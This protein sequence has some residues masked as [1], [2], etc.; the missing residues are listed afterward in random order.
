MKKIRTL[1]ILGLAIIL[2]LLMAAI[3]AVPALAYTYDA[4]IDP[5]EG[6]IGT[7]ITVVGESWGWSDTY[8]RWVTIFF[9]DEEADV[10][11][12]IDDEVE[13]Y[14]KVVSM[15]TVEEDDDGSFEATFDVPDTLSDGADDVDVESGDYFLYFTVTNETA[16]EVSTLIRE[17]V[18]F[19]VTSSGDVEID[20]EEGPVDTF[21]EITGEDFISKKDIEIDFDGHEIDIEDGDDKTDSNGDFQSF[22][23]IPEST[24]GDHTI[25]VIVSSSE[26]EVDFTVEPDIIITPQSGEAGTEVT[27]SGTGFA[28]RPEQAVIYFNNQSVNVFGD[29]NTSGSF[30]TTFTVP[31]G[32]NAGVYDIEAED[33]DDNLATAKFTLTVTP[34]PEPTPTPEPEPEPQPTPQP[35]PG[36]EPSPTDL[37]ISSNS[38][39][40]GSLI[41]IGGAGFTPGGTATLKYD[42]ITIATTQIDSGGMF[43]VT[44]DVP[45]STHGKHTITVTDGTHSNQVT[46]TVESVAPKTPTPFL[47]EMGVKAKSPAFFDWADVTDASLPV[48]YVLQIASNELFTA[49]SIVLEKPA[50]LE[51]S[52]TL[53]EQEELDLAGQETPYYWRVK[54]VDAASNESAWTGAGE[55]YAGTS[56]EFPNWALYTLLGIG[57]VLLFGLGYWLGRRTAF[58]Y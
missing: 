50:L 42:D 23:I 57:A 18:E 24:A 11:D 43:M 29:M 55:F 31:A 9:S 38:D 36:P 20:P 41:G 16:T 45:P 52:Y 28:R 22:I 27:I 46:Y 7:E 34:Q 25:T 47:P 26:V 19:T 40:I 30:S 48:T 58:Y 53:S 14:D 10:N 3:P 35:E 32:L 17:V 21:V 44:F 56:S 39:A 6:P 12:N 15:A 2:S 4:E 13:N 8:E 51:S 49:G 54:A 5:E 37:S 33:G 1:R